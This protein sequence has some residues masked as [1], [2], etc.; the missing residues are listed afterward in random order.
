MKSCFN[1]RMQHICKHYQRIFDKFELCSF[2]KDM[3]GFINSI[4]N[5]IGERCKYYT[6]FTEEEKEGTN[7][8]TKE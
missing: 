7:E 5:A 2:M 1:C 8:T 3:S 4:V 6:E